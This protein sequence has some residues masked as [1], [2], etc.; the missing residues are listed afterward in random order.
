MD[1]DPS[2]EEDEW[3]DEA[4][5]PKFANVCIK[6]IAQERRDW[7]KLLGDAHGVVLARPPSPSTLWGQDMSRAQGNDV[8]EGAIAHASEQFQLLLGAIDDYT[9]NFL[10]MLRHDRLLIQPAW[11]AVRGIMEAAL[12]SC[13]L[14]DSTKTPEMRLARAL[15]LLPSTIQ[16]AIDTLQK[17]TADSGELAKKREART[18]LIDY[19]ERHG[20]EVL[21]KRDKRGHRT[22]VTNAVVFEGQKA[23]F[24]LN[25]TQLAEW[26]LPDSPYLYPLLSGAAHSEFWLLNGVRPN[27]AGEA[28]NSVVMPLFVISAGFVTSACA[29]FGLDERPYLRSNERRTMALLM[30]GGGATLKPD[31]VTAFGRIG[32]GLPHEFSRKGG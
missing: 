2:V 18:D 22:D 27:S 14:L 8:L 29:Y 17:F 23:S 4:N 19:F 6:L 20:V 5:R 12:L 16:G 21:W 13:W 32:S 3:D 9:E 1:N 24:N 15:S 10:L 7:T 25:V 28:L 26:Y 30:R 11:S 31:R